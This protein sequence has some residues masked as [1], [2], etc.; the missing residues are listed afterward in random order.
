MSWHFLRRSRPVPS[1]GP[2]ML[3]IP[4]DMRAST[5]VRNFKTAARVCSGAQRRSILYK[6]CGLGGLVLNGRARL[7][8]I[9]SLTA[10]SPPFSVPPLLPAHRVARGLALWLAWSL[11]VRH[12]AAGADAD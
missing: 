12:R 7:I 11:H 3:S 9:A 10:S 5:Q 1:T 2:A 4:S 8:G 6:P